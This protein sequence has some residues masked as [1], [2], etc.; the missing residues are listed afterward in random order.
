MNR[1]HFFLADWAKTVNRTA[2]DVQDPAQ[3]GL[4]DWHH[5]GFAGVFGSRAPDQTVGN[6]HGNRPDHIIAQVL[7][8]FD[9]QVIRFIIDGRIGNQQ[10]ILNRRQ[11]AWREFHVYDRSH[12]LRNLSYIL[13]HL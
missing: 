1:H 3:A 4:A 12:D 11:I 5:D 6:V 9:H 13:S 7:G 10:R 8:H 2:H